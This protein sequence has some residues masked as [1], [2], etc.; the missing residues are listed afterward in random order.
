MQIGISEHE[1]L[2]VCLDAP[3][4]IHSVEHICPMA[5]K[6]TL[7]HTETHTC[8]LHRYKQEGDTSVRPLNLSAPVEELKTVTQCRLP[9]LTRPRPETVR[10]LR[11]PT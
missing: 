4:I 2:Q 1:L 8:V 9:P 6:H 3:A 10:P 5:C 11:V 7:T